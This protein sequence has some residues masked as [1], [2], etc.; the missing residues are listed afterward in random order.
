MIVA[1]LLAAALSAYA[2]AWLLQLRSFRVGSDPDR[3]APTRLTLAGAGLH[4]AGLAMFWVVYRAP[5]LVGFGPAA[6]TLG[7]GFTVVLLI[8]SRALDRRTAGLLVLP[9]AML[10][11]AAALLAGI[12]PVAPT[13]GARTVWFVGHVAFVLAGYSMLFL[14][15]VAAAMYLLQ[16]RALK[17][18]DFGNV[19]RAFPSLESLDRM[20]AIALAGGLA[21]LIIGL[22]TG[23]SFALTFGRGVA[24][25]DRDVGF[26]LLTAAAY[27][28][29]LVPRLSPA[30]HG[31]RV[32]RVT[33]LALAVCAVT[34]ALL[35]LFSPAREFFL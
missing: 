15:S 27:G 4:A 21:A 8:T 20:N 32:A 29:A 6:A 31:P 22:V 25:T 3:S 5:P 24:I 30:G 9:A 10:V 18:R 28:A 2:V 14:G 13:T 35:R 23:W 12:E 16:F 1:A 11:L 19:F 7:L 33:L 17:R 26:G 34:F